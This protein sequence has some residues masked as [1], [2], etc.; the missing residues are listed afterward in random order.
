MRLK[1][2]RTCRNW[3]PRSRKIITWRWP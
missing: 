1:W 3:V 2:A